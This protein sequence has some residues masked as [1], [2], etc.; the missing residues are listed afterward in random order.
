MRRHDFPV[1][2]PFRQQINFLL[3]L[4]AGQRFVCHKVV[5]I[6]EHDNRRRHPFPLL[7]FRVG[8]GLASFVEGEAHLITIGINRYV[9]TGEGR[10][11]MRDINHRPASYRLPVLL[12]RALRHKHII[13]IL[14]LAEHIHQ[15]AIKRIR[16][17]SPL[18]VERMP[19]ATAHVLRRLFVQFVVTRHRIGRVSIMRRLDPHRLLAPITRHAARRIMRAPIVYI[20]APFPRE[21]GLGRV[22]RLGSVLH[23]AGMGKI[24]REMLMAACFTI[25]TAITIRVR[26]F[27]VDNL[28]CI[29]GKLD[30]IPRFIQDRFPQ[31]DAGMI[32]V[33]AY[34]IADVAIHTFAKLRRIVPELP[35][36]RIHNHKQP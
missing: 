4:R 12:Y 35:A 36:R 30:R 1:H 28:T 34:Q 11:L 27:L 24:D 10:H 21:I 9:S 31:P 29:L 13:R 2:Q 3:L 15:S 25:A 18:M 32:S 19:Q 22:I 26:I 6:R 20:V 14:R 33:P 16:M 7:V 5:N 8:I 23:I 17:V